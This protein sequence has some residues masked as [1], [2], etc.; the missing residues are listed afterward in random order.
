MTW[1]CYLGSRAKPCPF[2]GCKMIGTDTKAD[3]EA[4]HLRGLPVGCNRCKAELWWFP[5][6]LAADPTYEQALANALRKWNR[7]R[8]AA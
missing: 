5:K 6:D 3:F 8:D 2:C 4:L 7:R 1:D